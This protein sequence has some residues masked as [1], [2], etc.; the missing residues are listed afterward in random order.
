MQLAINERIFYRFNDFYQFSSNQI[1]NILSQECKLFEEILEKTKPDYFITTLTSFHH[2]HLFYEICKRKNIKVLM[3]YM[4]KL[5]HRCVISQQANHLDFEIKLSDVKTKNRSFDELLDYFKSFDIVKQIE[6]YKSKAGT[7]KLKKFRA[8]KNFLKNGDQNSNQTNYPYYGRDRSKVIL[9]EIKK[10]RQVQ[11]RYSFIN[12]NL[13]R[14]IPQNEKFVYY[15]LH[16]EQERNLLLAAPFFTNQIELIRN[17]AKSLPINYKLLVKEHPAQETREWRAISDYKKIMKI[18]NVIL[19]HPA[20]PSQEILERCS[21]VVTIGGTTGLEAAFYR[22]PSIILSQMDYS[23]LPSVEFVQDVHKLSN[24]IK[25][26]LEKEVKA[27]DLDRFIQIYEKNSFEFDY[28]DFVT[29]YH[30]SFY[31]NGNLLD[32]KINE[33]DMRLFL[34]ENE[35]ILKKVTNEHIEKIKKFNRREINEK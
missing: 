25:E 28:M 13:G 10:S 34:Q 9:F 12:K 26:S 23:I 27:D 11:K 4:S 14:N 31:F 1:L 5:G 21:L 17:I 29:K 24:K 20:V 33:N 16:I 7:S 6:N 19:I 30:E 32:T 18:P 35:N 22:K 8:L 2:D 15:P 3:I